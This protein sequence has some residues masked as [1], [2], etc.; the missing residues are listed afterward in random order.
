MLAA[1][2]TL[3]S[4]LNCFGDDVHARDPASLSTPSA[5]SRGPG[6]DGYRFGS[7]FPGFVEESLDGDLLLLPGAGLNEAR[8]AA[9][10]EDEATIAASAARLDGEKLRAG[11]LLAG[12]MSSDGSM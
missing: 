9:T 6:G 10:V 3:L 5:L 11:G 4:Q 1:E 12:S 8:R 2:A 7:S